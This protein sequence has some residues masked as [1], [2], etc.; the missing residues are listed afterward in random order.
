MIIVAGQIVVEPDQR[1]AYPARAALR[2]SSKRAT[3]PAAWTSR[4][5]RT[6]SARVVST[7]SSA[8]NRQTQS[9]RSAAT[10]PARSSRPEMISASVSE[11]EVSAVRDLT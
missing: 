3:R 6:S 10:V 1:E 2:S 7:C 4:L 8:G 11:Y 9:G 5:P